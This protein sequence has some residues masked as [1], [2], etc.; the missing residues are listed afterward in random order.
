MFLIFVTIDENAIEYETRLK[1]EL[2]FWLNSGLR[3]EVTSVMSTLSGN[4]KKQIE[5][6]TSNVRS[7]GRD[8]ATL[9]D[10]TFQKSHFFNM[11]L[12]LYSQ[13]RLPAIVFCL[14]RDLCEE[15]VEDTVVTLENMEARTLEAEAGDS[16][17]KAKQRDQQKMLKRLKK[18]RDAALKAKN[19]TKEENER[20]A[21]DNL[22]DVAGEE[23]EDL[24]EVDPR[25]SFLKE[26]HTYT[27]T[28]TYTILLR[29]L[30]STTINTCNMV[31]AKD[32]SAFFKSCPFSFFCFVRIC[33]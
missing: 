3:D 26:V 28:H 14:D 30:T 16:K 24:Y 27:Y 5:I 10:N 33:V 1:N 31:S 17:A 29:T 25:F 18:E 9:W 15:L 11:L 19:K 22:L 13:D 32:H 23:R 21:Q 6:M 2:T 8:E 7:N 4:L 12:E 20:D